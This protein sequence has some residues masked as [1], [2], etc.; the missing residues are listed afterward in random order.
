M[1]SIKLGRES[2][3]LYHM[4]FQS[5]DEGFAIGEMIFDQEGKPIDYIVRYV[6]P[7]YEKQSGLR[8]EKVIG[9]R[10]SE[11]LDTVETLWIEQFGKVVSSGKSKKFEGYNVCLDRWFS[12]NAFPL[13]IKNQFGMTFN[14][15]TEHKRIGE[16]LRTSEERKA[17]LLRLSDTLRPLADPMEIYGTVTRT[18]MDYFGAD[19]CYYC[20]IE[21]NEA[22]IRQ[23]AK[24]GDLP[25]V[26]GVY[27]LSNYPI[28]KS[29]NEAGL[30]FSVSDVHSAEMIEE[31]LRQL[32]IQLKVISYLDVPVLKNGKL[33]GIL[34]ITQCTPRDWTDLETELAAEV[35]ER[36][37][38]A[39]ERAKTEEILRKS[40]AQFRALVAASS[41]IVCRM[42]P[43]WDA[44]H[45]LQGSDFMPE[46]DGPNSTWVDK[47]IPLDNQQQVWEVINEAIQTKSIFELVHRFVKMDGTLGWA[48]SRAIPLLDENGEIEEWIGTVSDITARKQNEETL[49]M[50]N[51]A[52]SKA[53]DMKD[54]FLS[55][56]S[57][58]FRTPLT[59]IISAIQ[60][61]TSQYVSELSDKS[62]GYF[63]IIR[64]NANRQ[65][66]LVN[67]ILDITRIN[68]GVLTLH[69]VNMDI[70]PLARLIMESIRPYAE[71]KN[72]GISF[73][74]DTEKI[75]M[76]VDEEKFE[77][78]LLNLLSNA[79]K[80]TPKGKSVNI[81]L[82][83]RKVN[84]KTVA[85]IQLLDEGIGIPA[86]KQEHIFERF[87]QV[88]T[89]LSRQAEGTG[90]G[91]YLTRMFVEMMGGEIKLSSKLGEGSTFT[92]LLPVTKIKD[93]KSEKMISEMA[94]SRI[95][96]YTAIEFSDVY[97]K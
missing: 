4:L 27:P 40:E 72:I 26:A 79:I 5:M 44:M 14:N 22:V 93:T 23:D 87:G 38:A 42:S 80:Y 30:P 76:G 45:H 33:V 65:L 82:S 37:W 36:T 61:L 92:V 21:N 7:A 95:I 50:S 86:D 85:C 74:V 75:I 24:C 68:A 55:L 20:E 94:D 73:T 32:Y 1:G 90:I 35:A 77:R 49:Q 41:N 39:A 96:Q 66:K 62:K 52:L 48:F 16:L 54:E 63:N 67:N 60:M 57:H 15:I 70:V 58:E 81:K 12:V 64:Q 69:S 84:K 91:L 89:V 19:R 34:C 3:N 83:K 47:Y 51:E 8:A 2:E 29:L 17:F 97:L 9:M 31:E 13:P 71:R 88:D 10:V 6:N 78:I 56:I 28:Q 43:N 18:A 53:L 59:I 11:L 46:K 25:S